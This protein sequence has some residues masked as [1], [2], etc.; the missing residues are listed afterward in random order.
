MQLYDDIYMEPNK[1]GTVVGIVIP[2]PPAG[3]PD[4]ETARCYIKFT[5]QVCARPDTL[6]SSCAKLCYA[7][8]SLFVVLSLP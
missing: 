4:M 8:Y 3:L 2:A 6:H 7:D 1:C 5:T